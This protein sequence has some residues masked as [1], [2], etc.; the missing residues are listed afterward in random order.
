MLCSAPKSPK[1]PIQFSKMPTRFWWTKSDQQIRRIPLRG[2]AIFLCFLSLLAV[3]CKPNTDPPALQL[4]QRT[5]PSMGTELRLTAWTA[6]EPATLAAFGNILKE[7]D[8][9]EGLMSNWKKDSE[10]ERVNAAAGRNAVAVGPEIRSVLNT[11]RQMSEWTEGKFDITWGVLSGLWKFDYQNKDGSIPGRGEVAR[12]R[13]LIDYREV[14]VDDKAGTVFIRRKGMVVNLGGIGK[15][16]AVD[17]A[18]QILLQHGVK[19]FMVQF[20][21]DLYVAGKAGDRPWRLG[22]QDPRGPADK[23]FA[24][25]ELSD[26][27]FSTSGDYERFFMKDGRRYHHIIDPATGE[28]SPNS[29]SVTLLASDATVADGLSKGVFI[30]GPDKGMALI[31]RLPGVEGIIVGANNKVLVSSG[32]EGRVKLLSPPTD[33]P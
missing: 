6:D 20:G 17:R 32:L 11:A 18:R 27:T 3:A 25:V 8:R 31:E 7:F 23:I 19:N 4:V 15:G 16:Y 21:G 24:S 10:I 30:L 13:K 28:P 29:R 2:P 22:I 9:F 14:E 5:A 12:R 33:A 1:M 26:S